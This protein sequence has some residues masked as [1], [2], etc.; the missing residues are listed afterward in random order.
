LR[1][2]ATDM[3]S[4]FAHHALL[5]MNQSEISDSSMGVGLRVVTSIV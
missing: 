2:S 1:T 4:F 3:A 5:I